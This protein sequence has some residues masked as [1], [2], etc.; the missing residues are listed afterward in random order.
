MNPLANRITAGFGDIPHI[1]PDAN[2]VEEFTW[3]Y[4]ILSANGGPVWDGSRIQAAPA[5]SWGSRIGNPPPNNQGPFGNTLQNTEGKVFNASVT[6]LKGNHTFKAGYFYHWSIQARS[7]GAFLGDINFGND[8]SGANTFDTGFGFAN[9]ATG[10]FTTY[11]QVSRLPE[12]GHIGI[13]HEWFIQ[14]TWKAG[15][16]LTLDYGVRFVRQR[17][18]YDSYFRSANFLPDRWVEADAPLLYVPGCTGGRTTCS[19]N[20][21]RQAKHPVT[22]AL[23]GPNSASAI[24]TIVPGTGNPLNGLFT[25]EQILPDLY[26]FPALAVAPRF[27]AAWD[28]KGTQSLVLRGS[29]GLFYDREGVNLGRQMIT[30]P[31]YTRNV[32]RRAGQ[33][34]DFNSG[35]ATESA[36]ALVAMPF[37]APIP[38]SVQWSTGVQMTAPYA[39]VLD[40]AYR[41]TRGY[42]LMALNDHARHLNHFDFGAAFLAKNEDPTR[43]GTSTVPGATSLVSL[44]PDLVRAF[45]G[46]GTIAQQGGFP[47][48]RRYHGIELGVT[49]RMRNGWSFG[50]IDSIS[51]YDREQSPFR[52]QHNA[53]GSVTARADQAEAD[54]LLGNLAPRPHIMRANFNWQVPGLTFDG[55]VSRYAVDGAERLE[56]LGD[57]ARRERQRLLRELHLSERRRQREH[58]RHAK[59]WRAC[60]Y[61]WRSW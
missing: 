32:T 6:K 27:G 15:S 50:F 3:S 51:L 28:V 36:P 57:L 53:D 17:A 56:S 5:F 8:N 58:H 42:N 29:L 47:G 55:P 49:R 2:K 24:G 40:V 46:Y 61:Q 22:G 20:T 19:G 23:L 37:E 16:D 1:F 41:G 48:W 60:S 21:D 10:N 25:H 13:N 4:K 30:N 34:Q 59:L 52:V 31:P 9:A 38:A 35:L 7:I 14:D 26:K 43:T 44:H 12:G 18:A 45:P 11:Q 33:F 39:T 54:R